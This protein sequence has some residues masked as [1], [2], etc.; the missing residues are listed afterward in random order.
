MTKK[1]LT[2]LW[3]N[4]LYKRLSPWI[5]EEGYITYNWASIVDNNFED[6]DKDYIDTFE[7][8]NI[9]TRMYNLEFEPHPEDESLIRPKQ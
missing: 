5:N 9:Y 8:T 6:W 1:Q 2:V 4:Q 3:G 7:R